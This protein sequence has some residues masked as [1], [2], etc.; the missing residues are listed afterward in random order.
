LI[1]GVEFILFR[2]LM[3]DYQGQAMP[4]KAYGVIL[5]KDDSIDTEAT[6]FTGQKR[7]SY[8]NSPAYP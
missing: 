2:S 4:E 8:D 1:D 5:S 6:K 3:I 7:Q